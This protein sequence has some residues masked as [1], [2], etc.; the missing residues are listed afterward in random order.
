MKASN[1]GMGIE[2]RNGIMLE[3]CDSTGITICKTCL[4]NK[5]EKSNYLKPLELIV[6]KPHT[7]LKSGQELYKKR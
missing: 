1:A 3:F 5:K 7:D 6:I 2:I 4:K